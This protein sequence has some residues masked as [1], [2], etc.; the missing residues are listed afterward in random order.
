MTDFLSR[1][2]KVEL[3][4][5]FVNVPPPWLSVFIYYYWFGYLGL[6]KFELGPRREKLISSWRQV[7]PSLASS[8][9]KIKTLDGFLP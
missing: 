2:F 5:S 9:E 1:I 6:G 4:S 3:G 7:A 8:L